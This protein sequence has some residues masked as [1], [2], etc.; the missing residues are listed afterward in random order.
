MDWIA[1]VVKGRDAKFCVTIAALWAKASASIDSDRYFFSA[2]VPVV[3]PVEGD[4]LLF[5]E[6]V[7][8]ALNEL[9]D[10]PASGRAAP[11]NLKR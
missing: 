3:F 7:V 8:Q 6:F 2:H 4:Q 10:K 11:G 9:V 5:H 1:S